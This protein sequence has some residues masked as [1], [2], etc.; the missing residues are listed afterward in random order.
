MDVTSLRDQLTG[1][2]R[3]HIDRSLGRTIPVV[4]S[5]D[6]L[7]ALVKAMPVPDF[8]AGNGWEGKP[9]FPD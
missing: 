7:I 2:Y 5:A 4:T 3:G 9:P 1:L 8:E 6:E